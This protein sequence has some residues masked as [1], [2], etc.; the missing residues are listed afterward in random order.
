MTATTMRIAWATPFNERSAIAR[1]SDIVTAEIASRGMAVEILRTEMDK[2]RA[3]PPLPTA[4]P[5]R[6]P[7]RHKPEALRQEFDL[8]VVNLGDYFAFHGGALYLMSELPALAIFHDAYLRNLVAGWREASGLDATELAGL[9]RIGIIDQGDWCDLPWLA[10]MALGAVAHGSH[11]ADVIRQACPGPV[12]AIPLAFPDS[13]PAPRRAGQDGDF[14]VTTI[15]IMNANKQMDRVIGALGASVELRQRAI[16]RLIGPI[17]DSERQRLL[18][19]AQAAGIRTPEIFGWVP[20]ERL[21]ELLGEADAICCLRYP[22][23]EGGS[24]SLITSL[25]SGRPTVVADAGAYAEVPDDLVWK[26]PYGAQPSELTPV[27]EA[28]AADPDGADRRAAKARAWAVDTYSAKAYV[29]A[30]LPHMKS[31]LNWTPVI[32]A[33]RGLGTILSQFGLDAS[34]PAAGR[35]G[36]ILA[37]FFSP[38]AGMTK[39]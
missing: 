27:L 11:Y 38:K 17:E 4:V 6:P 8:V 23:M 3:L 24:A 16:Y 26:V 21:Q 29:D 22:I 37:E 19:L 10:T 12:A 30:L 5:V 39:R 15:G 1:V 14:V 13:G 20:D 2:A 32:D 35:I 25:Y 33:G 18:G 36:R 9:C 31:C 34:D 28:I 7:G